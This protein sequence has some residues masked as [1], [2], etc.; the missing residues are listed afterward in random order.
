MTHFINQNGTLMPMPSGMI[1]DSL[2]L[3]TYSA[4]LDPN[5]GYFLSKIDD[6]KT[7]Y[8]IYGNVTN[9][10]KRI[11]NTFMDR[12]NS[13]GVLLVGNKGTGKTMLA[14]LVSETARN[15]LGVSTIVVNSALS[16][17]GFNKF[18]TS[19]TQPCIV[20]FDE[21]EKVYDVDQQSELLTL[22]DG[23]YPSKKLFILTS[24][25]R[26]EVSNYLIDRPGRIFY[27]FEYGKIPLAEVSEYL[28]DNLADKSKV[29]EV[30]YMCS[31]VNGLSYDILKAIC[32]DVNRYP[33]EQ[34][35]ETFSALNISAGGEWSTYNVIK[36]TGPWADAIGKG[37]RVSPLSSMFNIKNFIKDYPFPKNADVTTMT[38]GPHH[39]TSFSPDVVTYEKDGYTLTLERAEEKTKSFVGA[40]TAFMKGDT[41][42]ATLR[43]YRSD[44]IVDDYD[45]DDEYTPEIYEDAQEAKT[46]W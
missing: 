24:N 10:S 12:P 37:S 34:L 38:I 44:V 27:N 26:Y 14:K 25:D 39:I 41:Q 11:L 17:E 22:F 45:E 21:F 46:G 43:N 1:E 42:V 16:G 2:P 3:G 4:G 8:K 23:V 15:S 20:I 30:S 35:D 19:I 7:G 40:A 13:T 32:E 33:N 29:Q 18:I 28:Q 31:M 6:I 9:R 36:G 5:R